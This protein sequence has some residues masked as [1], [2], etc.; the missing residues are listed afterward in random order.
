MARDAEIKVLQQQL[1]DTNSSL[2]SLT[3]RH[4]EEIQELQAQLEGERGGLQEVILARQD[5]ITS[6]REQLEVEQQSLQ[7]LRD[8]LTAKQE[9]LLVAETTLA[10]L[11]HDKERALHLLDQQ[12][13]E[14][15]NLARARDL[16]TAEAS[17]VT[18][19]LEQ[20]DVQLA[21][22]TEESSALQQQLEHLLGMRFDVKLASTRDEILAL[23]HVLQEQQQRLSEQA[24]EGLRLQTELSKTSQQLA[25]TLSQKA[26]VQDQLGVATASTGNRSAAAAVGGSSGR[27]SAA[28][29]CRS[30]DRHEACS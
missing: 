3:T 18:A 24:Q 15:T 11:N 26:L 20:K 5:A 14:L 4:A 21:Q 30:S 1:V 9:A 13:E 8:E 16:A 23:K 7:V 6:L 28:G 12:Q 19:S 27:S 29:I 2:A 10:G 22:L 25:D 17:I